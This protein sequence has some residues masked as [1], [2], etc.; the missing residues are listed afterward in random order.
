M[1]RLS[2]LYKLGLDLSDIARIRR[3][4][5]AAI[6]RSNNELINSFTKDNRP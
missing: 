2:E 6:E 4:V 1:S 5:L 3:D